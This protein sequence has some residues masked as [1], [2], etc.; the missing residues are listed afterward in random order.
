M[1]LAIEELRWTKKNTNQN[2][3]ISHH[4]LKQLGVYVTD[5]FQNSS[6]FG[7]KFLFSVR[8]NDYPDYPSK[9]GDV[10]HFGKNNY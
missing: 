2:I 10:Q 1:D 8:Y 7:I 4:S 9:L 6:I 3:S 5:A